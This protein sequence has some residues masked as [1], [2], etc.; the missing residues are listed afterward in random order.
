MARRENRVNIHERLNAIQKCRQPEKDRKASKLLSAR[1][2][3][4]QRSIRDSYENP[5][6]AHDKRNESECDVHEQSD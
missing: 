1:L 4:R 6:A 5:V 3:S 2:Y